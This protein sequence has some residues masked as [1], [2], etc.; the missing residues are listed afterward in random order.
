MP[1]SS[2]RVTEIFT[3]CLSGKDNPNMLVVEG[4]VRKFGFDKEKLDVH[5]QEIHNMLLQLPSEFIDG[6]GWSFLNACADKDG[7]QWT[8][9]QAVV[10][11][12]V[13]LGIGIGKV[14]YCMPRELWSVLPGGVPYFVVTR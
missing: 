11:Q 3:A 13:C 4:V 14:E 7:D 8:G 9:D 5:A 1:I 12:L 2:E 10:D 6:G